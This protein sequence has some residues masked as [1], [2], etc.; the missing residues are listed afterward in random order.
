MRDLRLRV[1]VDTN[2]VFE[3]VTQRN[4]AAGWIVDAWL[5][6]LFRP[7]ISNALAYE[8][9]EVLATKLST[10]RWELIRPLLLGLLDMAEPVVVHFSWRP[11]SPDPGDEHVIDCA[12]NAAAVIVTSNVRDFRRAQSELGIPV[13]TPVQFLRRL[14]E[15]SET[16][17]A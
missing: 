14:K 9:R 10:Q 5:K 2:V 12:M 6:G 3:G 11:S 4:T 1:V 17:Q 15:A 8:Y 13:A 7:C 16:A